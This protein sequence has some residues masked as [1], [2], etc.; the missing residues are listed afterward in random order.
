MHPGEQKPFTVLV[1]T[2]EA[3]AAA[4]VET[5][6][7]SALHSTFETNTFAPLAVTQAFLPFIRETGARVVFMSALCA[8]MTPPLLGGLCASKAALECTSISHRRLYRARYTPYW[9]SSDHPHT[10][11]RTP[12]NTSAR[13]RAPEGA[14]A[15]RHLRLEHRALHRPR[16]RRRR[17]RGRGAGRPRVRAPLRRRQE[18]P[19][20][21]PR[22]P[23]HRAGDGLY[24][25]RAHPLRLEPASQGP[26][27]RRPRGPRAGAAGGGALMGAPAPAAGRVAGLSRCRL[28]NVCDVCRVL[29]YD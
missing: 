24:H 17:C 8:G 23:G 1:H 12:L 27:P 2:S 19:R 22:R 21:P 13:R 11:T 6:E 15:L 3:V 10:H 18:A 14:R 9:Y 29:L 20:R 16:S 25:A 7:L 4:P 26:L 5:Q 28:L